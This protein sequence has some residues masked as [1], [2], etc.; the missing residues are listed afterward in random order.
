MTAPNSALAVITAVLLLVLVNVITV[1]AF[2]AFAAFALD[3]RRSLTGKWRISEARL[4][5]L[6]ALGGSPGA[7]WARNRYRHKTRKQPFVGRLQL[8]AMVQVGV[9]AGLAI[10]F[11]F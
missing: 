5:W 7:F 6:A 8:I 9:I 4:L 3:K 1:A 2:A 10:A 11:A